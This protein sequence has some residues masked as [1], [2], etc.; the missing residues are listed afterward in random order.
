[1]RSAPPPLRWRATV[2]AAAIVSYTTSGA[3]ALRAARERP[4]APILVLTLEARHRPPPRGAMG[5]ALR[6]HERRQELHRHGA[7]SGAH[8]ALVRGSP[9]PAS[10]SSLPPASRSALPA[11]P[12][13]C[14]SPGS[15]AEATIQHGGGGLVPATAARSAIGDRVPHRN[16]SEYGSCACCDRRCL[17]MSER[18]TAM[19]VHEDR[20]QLLVST[21]VH[22]LF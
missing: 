10:A 4:A 1:M 13:F 22:S 17:G 16:A 18:P 6:P 14:A 7:K 15:T 3:T 20:R 5:R 21:L 2:G 19:L 12:T 8:R 9:R 11:P